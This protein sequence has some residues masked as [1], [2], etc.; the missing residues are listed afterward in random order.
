MTQ[1]LNKRLQTIPWSSSWG[2]AGS[3]ISSPLS[4]ELCHLLLH[5]FAFELFL[6]QHLKARD[7]RVPL[8]VLLVCLGCK[9]VERQNHYLCCGGMEKCLQITPKMKGLRGWLR[10]LCL[11]LISNKVTKE[12]LECCLRKCWK[13][14]VKICNK[15]RRRQQHDDSP[16]NT[17][18]FLHVFHLL[19]EQLCIT[20]IFLFFWEVKDTERQFHFHQSWHWVVLTNLISTE[21]E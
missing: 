6:E 10:R 1:I 7:R 5:L 17:S 14:I 3:A 8:G 16:V 4:Y 11:F 2:V 21:L 20:S 13:N 18:Q 15:L 9:Q 12:S 19:S